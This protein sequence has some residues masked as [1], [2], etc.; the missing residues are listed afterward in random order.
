MTLSQFDL[1]NLEPLPFTV[2]W[3]VRVW[4]LCLAFP[5]PYQGSFLHWHGSGV[6][7]RNRQGGGTAFIYYG[8]WWDQRIWQAI[9]N[10]NKDYKYWIIIFLPCNNCSKTFFFFFFFGTGRYIL[11]TCV[12]QNAKVFFFFF[13]IYLH[14]TLA[15]FIV[16]VNIVHNLAFLIVWDSSIKK[17]SLS[18]SLYV[19]IYWV[20][21]CPSIH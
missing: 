21:A 4:K 3:T 7:R 5:L 2:Q 10:Q 6:W 19:Y 9:I 8:L 20:H 15:L 17:I 12:T 11:L 1:K 18:L 13:L 14:T 16:H